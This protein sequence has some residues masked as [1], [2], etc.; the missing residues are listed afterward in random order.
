MSK[1]LFPIDHQNIKAARDHIR[2]Q[3][4]KKS[5]WPT[6]GPRQAEEEF[7]SMKDRPETLAEWC[8]KWLDGS[9]WRQLKIAVDK[10]TSSPTAIG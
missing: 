1:K 8:T 4:A 7:E 6:E 5:W 2:E 10:E 3:F 9:Q